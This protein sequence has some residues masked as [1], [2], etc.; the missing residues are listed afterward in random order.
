[1]DQSDNG[2]GGRRD[3][4]QHRRWLWVAAAVA[5]AATLVAMY[6]YE[7]SLED[8]LEAMLRAAVQKFEADSPILDEHEKDGPD[9]NQP[10]E[11]G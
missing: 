6:V 3:R 11:R 4:S 9:A 10:A 7:K 1:M 5:V 2:Q 8:D